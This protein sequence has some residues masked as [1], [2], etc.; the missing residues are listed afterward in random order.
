MRVHVGVHTSSHHGRRLHEPFNNCLNNARPPQ[1]QDFVPGLASAVTP[2]EPEI[3]GIFVFPLVALISFHHPL[4]PQPP[5]SV[6]HLF[7][8]AALLIVQ[9]CFLFFFTSRSFCLFGSL[10]SGKMKAD[11]VSL[12]ELA[13]QSP[14]LSVTFST[15]VC[16][17]TFGFFF[18][19]LFILEIRMSFFYSSSSPGFPFWRL[20]S[21]A[22]KRREGRQNQV[23][24]KRAERL[25]NQS[26]RL[27]NTDISASPFHS[28]HM[29]DQMCTLF[30]LE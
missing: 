11:V 15:A 4:P 6:F 13:S 3:S 10:L 25:Q 9:R 23:R 17:L 2:P 12:H 24:G 14:L 29:L 7:S 30:L 27:Q 18:R 16:R 20:Q 21:E 1:N 26:E 19:P 5:F 22:E 8:P 28:L